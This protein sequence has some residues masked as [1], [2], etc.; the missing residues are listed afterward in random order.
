MK[1]S[2]QI[3]KKDVREGKLCNHKFCDLCYCFVCDSL[4]SQCKMWNDLGDNGEKNHCLASDKGSHEYYWKKLREEHKSGKKKV[5]KCVSPSN[6]SAVDFSELLTNA[7]TSI[8]EEIVATSSPLL[9]RSGPYAPDDTIA[10]NDTTLTKC[11]KC[12]WFTKFNHNNFNKYKIETVHHKQKSTKVKRILELNEIGDK[13]WCHKCGRISDTRDFGKAQSTEYIPTRGDLFLGKQTIKFRILAHDPRQIP[14][15]QN[16]WKQFE[17]KTPEW[18]YDP[19]EAEYDMFRQRIGKFPT[20][21]VILDSIP[22]L[23]EKKIPKTGMVSIL[24]SSINKTKYC[25]TVSATETEAILL[26]HHNDKVL[27]EE[28]AKFPCIGEKNDV[29]KCFKNEP[30]RGTIKASWNKI[31]QEGVRNVNVC[32]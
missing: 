6:I 26:R 12:K 30:L 24:K 5:D 15:F 13:D 7:W 29:Q 32:G 25:T 21:Q 17:N 27:L 2:T 28:L 9:S 16:N 10:V 8:Q 19:K 4:A 22:I 3:A 14:P 23:E 1:L 18:T 31:R 20:I 11:R